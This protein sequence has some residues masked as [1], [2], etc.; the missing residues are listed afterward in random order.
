MNIIYSSNYKKE[1]TKWFCLHHAGGLGLDNFVS[2]KHLTAENINQAHQARWNYPDPM[3]GKFGGYNFFIGSLG[4][5]TQFRA[6]GS[7][8]MA[9][10]GYNF[11]GQV[12]SVC[13]AGNFNKH[14][15]TGKMVDEPTSEQVNALRGLYKAITEQKGI[16]IAPYNIV[17][18]RFFSQTDCFGSGLS[19]NWARNTILDRNTQLTIIQQMIAELFDLIRKLKAKQLGGGSTPCNEQLKD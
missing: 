15:I 18:H 3:T 10:K 5:I 19:D 6:I 12:I 7:E 4:E 14:S 8:T 11:N 2:T 16:S 17:P 1:N 13:L 9:Q